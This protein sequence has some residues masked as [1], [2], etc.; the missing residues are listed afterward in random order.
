MFEMAKKKKHNNGEHIEKTIAR[1]KEKER[2]TNW[3]MINLCWG[4]VGIV[5][6]SIFYYMYKS[7]N[8]LQYMDNVVIYSAIA[9][10]AAGI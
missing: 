6:L 7:P 4:I 2:L 1:R 3:Y 9:I 5:I 8:T 10:M